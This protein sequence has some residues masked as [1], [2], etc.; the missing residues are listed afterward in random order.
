MKDPKA[1]DPTK[2]GRAGACLRHQYWERA[3]RLRD[4]KTGGALTL[5]CW[6]RRA[7]KSGIQREGRGF[8]EWR[9]AASPF[10]HR[11]ICGQMFQ[12]LE[13]PTPLRLPVAT[14]TDTSFLILF[15]AA[16]KGI[17]SAPCPSTFESDVTLTQFY[18]D[19]IA[20]PIFFPILVH[21]ILPC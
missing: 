20:D 4:A 9:L 6:R 3:V 11:F 21:P 19:N 2:V 16:T 12:M 7:N 1:L 17:L 14:I 8:E 5:G 10:C 18:F 15:S 13:P